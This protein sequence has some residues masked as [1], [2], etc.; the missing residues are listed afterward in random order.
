MGKSTNFLITAAAALIS[1]H[2]RKKTING[3][4][5]M[6]DTNRNIRNLGRCYAYEVF[7]EQERLANICITGGTE[8]ARNCLLVQNCKQSVADGIPV[9]VIH[10][11]NH[12]LEYDIKQTLSSR[13]YC[14]SVSRSEPFY[15]PLMRL[16]DQEIAGLLIEASREE[17]AIGTDG[18]LYLKS[19][20]GIAR[21]KGITPYARMLSTFPYSQLQT[22]L[23]GLETKGI[24]NTAEA[25]AFRN[26]IAA[27]AGERSRI[28]K[29]FSELCSQ[30]DIVAGKGELARS[31]SLSECI[32]NRGLLIIDVGTCSKR[33]QLSFIRAELEKCIK[34]G[35]PVRVIVD[36]MTLADSALFLNLLG[37][38]Y[39]SFWWTLSTPDI[40]TLVNAGKN[41]S[42]WIALTHKTVMFANSLGTSEALSKELGEYDH[43]EVVNSHGG[44][45]GFGNIGLHFGVNNTVQTSMKRER[46]VK[47][48][49]ISTLGVR[50][51]IMLNNNTS[52]IMKGVLI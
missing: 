36:A 5:K 1:R 35:Q 39:S 7:P 21:K 44:G 14:R 52:E 41:L 10:E 20:S 9:I 27:G 18:L 22:I 48:E 2:N 16:N 23:S 17:D 26:D 15:E 47:P 34:E 51:F 38:T 3:I 40:N 49:D 8:E 43:V 4:R 31:T 6:N 13:C 33:T 50:E 11:S 32:R 19:I 24:I 45:T 30:G 25:A 12:H 37:K 29:F 46:V 28:E 42:S